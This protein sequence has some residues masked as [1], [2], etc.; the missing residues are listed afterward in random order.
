[1][2]R[3]INTFPSIFLMIFSIF[4]LKESIDM[5]KPI[6]GLVGVF[7][8]PGFFPVLLSISLLLLSVR[9][10]LRELK[11]S[12]PKGLNM[13]SILKSIELKRWMILALATALYIY[14]FDKFYF[15]ILTFIYLIF[16]FLFLKTESLSILKIIIS[17]LIATFVISYIIPLVFEMPLPFG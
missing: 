6:I 15:S 17:A 10:F 1:M 2:L 14:L 8:S 9:L 7:V 11:L 3:L 5:P 12:N 16:L 13:K 4:I